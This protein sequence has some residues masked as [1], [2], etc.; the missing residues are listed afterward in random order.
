[1]DKVSMF[2]FSLDFF[3]FNFIDLN[4]INNYILRGVNILIG[5]FFR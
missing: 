3:I 2:V 1:M 4:N 5:F